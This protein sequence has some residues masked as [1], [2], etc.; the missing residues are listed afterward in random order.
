[1]NVSWDQK[2]QEVRNFLFGDAAE[3]Q[4]VGILREIV[5]A[6]KAENPLRTHERECLEEP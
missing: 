3:S 2:K 6:S 4:R 5:V 1:M